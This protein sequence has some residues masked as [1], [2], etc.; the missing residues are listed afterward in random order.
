MKLNTKNFVPPSSFCQTSVKLHT[1]RKQNTAQSKLRAKGD[2]SGIPINP[3]QARKIY[4]LPKSAINNRSPRVVVRP[5]IP[6]RSAP[7]GLRISITT[8]T[9]IALKIPTNTS[10]VGQVHAIQLSI[11]PFLGQNPWQYSY[12]RNK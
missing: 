3:S 10:A 9:A 4:T 5:R 8:N 12:A 1:L 7:P 11:I 6:L 2:Q